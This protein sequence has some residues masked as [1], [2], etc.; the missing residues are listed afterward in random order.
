MSEMIERV[1][2]AL[3]ADIGVGGVQFNI[4]DPYKRI[5]TVQLSTADFIGMARAAARAMREPTEEMLEASQYPVSYN[6]NFSGVSP[7]PHLAWP[8]MIDAALK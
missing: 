8:R 3:F 7:P 4:S 6:N 5:L 2:R 1:A